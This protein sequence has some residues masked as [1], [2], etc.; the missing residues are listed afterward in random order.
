MASQVPE[1]R[2]SDLIAK[3]SFYKGFRHQDKNSLAKLALLQ[4]PSE[5]SQLSQSGPTPA[6]TYNGRTTFPWQQQRRIDTEG[7][8]VIHLDGSRDLEANSRKGEP[9][10]LQ[11]CATKL[12]LNWKW[13]V[14]ILLFVS[15]VVG[16]CVAVPMYLHQKHRG[17]RPTAANELTRTQQLATVSSL[18]A[19][20]LLTIAPSSDT[21][22]GAT[23]PL[24]C[25]TAEEALAP[26]L[27]SFATYKITDPAT[28]AA[29]VSTIAMESGDFKY[30]HHYFPFPVP[31]QGTRNMQSAAYNL[32]YARSI[33]GLAG[34]LEAAQ[35]AGPENV[36]DL[37]LSHPEYDFGSAA[38]FLT[39]QC[40]DGVVSGLAKAGTEAF[41]AYVGC[42]G[43][44]ASAQRTEYYTNALKA[45]GLA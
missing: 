22:S 38:W 20:S 16:L 35:A 3:T 30:S 11:R 42:I 33:P 23:H 36:I 31:G 10:R 29:V 41:D 8:H 12:K 27:A 6:P 7:L 43:A 26:I 2:D 5:K 17:D 4:P 15:I 28:Q 25:K 39:A 32:D 24:E 45:I 9:S 37:L 18:T 14:C 13:A 1:T 19:A 40:D 34:E 44:S 21:C